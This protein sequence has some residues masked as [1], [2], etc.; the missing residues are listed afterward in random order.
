MAARYV[1]RSPVLYA[2]PASTRSVLHGFERV[3]ATQYYKYELNAPY[4]SVGPH[5]LTAAT[6]KGDL[7]LC[8]IV[9]ATD[10]Q[11]QKAESKLRTLV[12]TFRA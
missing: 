5:S 12:D 3:C 8:L 2:H 10:K 9:S 11:W 1:I 6:T 4:A 7:L